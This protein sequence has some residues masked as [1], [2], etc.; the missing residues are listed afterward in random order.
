MILEK[1]FERIKQNIFHYYMEYKAHHFMMNF[2]NEKTNQLDKKKLNE[3]LDWID[4]CKIDKKYNQL[5]PI[6][7]LIIHYEKFND[8]KKKLINILKKVEIHSENKIEYIICLVSII[9]N[10]N[11]KHINIHRED[12]KKLFQKINL[13]DLQEQ[14]HQLMFI[15]NL[16]TH[17]LSQKIPLNKKDI[18]NVINQ[19]NDETLLSSLKMLLS[20]N[21]DAAYNKE[22]EFFYSFQFSTQEKKLEIIK[23]FN[24]QKIVQKI[25]KKL[26]INDYYND[27][28]N[29][30]EE[31]D[32]NKML[33]KI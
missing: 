14:E 9:R 11:M 33:K 5:N 17:V 32:N 30:I 18:Q 1:K 20:A 31:N 2:F 21:N 19:C 24:D 4:Y 3:Y 22:I 6:N 26:E 13:Q 28:N 16:M 12:F 27:L 29:E 8:K 7:F 25:I 10:H 23:D 15:S